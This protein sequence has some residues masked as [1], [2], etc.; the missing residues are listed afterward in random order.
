M[1]SLK[2]RLRLIHTF[3]F[4]LIFYPTSRSHHYFRFPNKPH[5]II[6]MNSQQLYIASSCCFESIIS[7]SSTDNRADLKQPLVEVQ[8]LESSSPSSSQEEQKIDNERRRLSNLV[9]VKSLCFGCFVG[10]LLQAVTFSAFLVINKR[11]G[12]NP[13]PEE[14]VA[15]LSYWTLSLLIHM[16]IAVYSIIWGGMLMTLTRKGSIYMRKKLDNDADHAPNTESVWTPRFLF[17]SGIGVLL[18]VIVGSYTAWGIIDIELGFPV[19]LTPLFSTFL[20]DVGLC[21]LMVKF[22]DWGHAARNAYDEPQEDDE[23]SFLV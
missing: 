22:F 9:L 1:F 20:W 16:D 5:R 18:G 17:L 7:S 3:N 11:W 21:Y 13:Q 10:L 6:T 14:S 12:E 19:S 4:R 2:N 8:D 23:D 15:V